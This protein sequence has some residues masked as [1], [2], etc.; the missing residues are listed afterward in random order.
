[1]QTL[2]S[3]RARRVVGFR[4]LTYTASTGVREGALAIWKAQHFKQADAYN[5]HMHINISAPGYDYINS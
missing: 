1:M 2:G 3:G 5:L 4:E